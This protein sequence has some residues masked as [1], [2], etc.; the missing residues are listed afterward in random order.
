[1][2]EVYLRSIDR[3][4]KKELETADGKVTILSPY[5]TSSTAE[6]IITKVP[7]TNCEVYTLFSV[8]NFA[9]GASSVKTLRNLFDAGYALFHLPRLHAKVVLVSGKLATIGSQN[10]T[11]NGIRNRE[12]S[13][14]I[15]SQNEVREIEGALEPWLVERQ[16]ISAEMI[17]DIER[18]L[19]QVRRLFL[20]SRRA[21]SDL[22]KKI[23]SFESTRE[24]QKEEERK[25]S[26]R[27]IQRRNRRIAEARTRVT[28]FVER[29]NISRELAA[30]FVRES[31]WSY[32]NPH[33]ERIPAPRHS[34]NMYGVDG[35][36]KVEF[37]NIFLVGRAISRCA[38]T[39]DQYLTTIK[40]GNYCNRDKLVN[41]LR[42]DVRGAVATRN[43]Y[44]YREYY[45]VEGSDMMFGNQSIGVDDFVQFALDIWN[46]NELITELDGE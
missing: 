21:A 18:L 45:P 9:S 29:T 41:K 10:L 23:W 5:L 17:S 31:A 22:E 12:A 8:E 16:T 39:I 42:L 43:G 15:N 6:A 26:N 4:W 38:Q 2:S 44:E 25:R 35:D 37:G 32:F 3:R 11:A 19:P 7:S 1:M 36:W 46:I 33:R 27:R 14:L 28:P 30:R 34:K 40:Q 13:L 20:S 24:Q